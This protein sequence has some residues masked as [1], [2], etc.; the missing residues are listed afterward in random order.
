MS[1]SRTEELEKASPG[2]EEGHAA[3]NIKVKE[4]E[5]VCQDPGVQRDRLCSGT[6][7]HPQTVGSVDETEGDH[8]DPEET[9]DKDHHSYNLTI[10]DKTTPASYM[11]DDEIWESNGVVQ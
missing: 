7:C 5:A 10:T 11:Y 8:V 9:A 6:S 4:S 3:G 1:G 2:G